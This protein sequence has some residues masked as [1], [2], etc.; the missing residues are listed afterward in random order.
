L[1]AKDVQIYLSKLA[2]P[3][4]VDQLQR[5]FK[6][7]PGEYAEKDILI[8]VYMPDLRKVASKNK[9]LPIAETK[10]LLKSKIHEERLL[11]LLIL[12]DQFKNGNLKDQETIYNLYLNNTQFINNWDLVDAS[13]HLIVGPFLEGK[14][15]KILEELA[16]SEN[17]WER[18]IAMMA[19]F[20]EIK[21]SKFK[22][23][24][25]IAKIL[26]NDSH[27]LIHKS[28]GWMLREVG[29][30]DLETEEQFLEK[31]ST[32]MPRTMLR[33]AIERF[34]KKKYRYFL[35]KKQSK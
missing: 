6:T 12:V 7:G 29:K 2:N 10:K 11:A 27:D 13:A 33:Y 31:H 19:T 17:L 14:S 4:R 25:K 32:K 22:T 23:A 34:P 15:K 26:L 20:N 16:K 8:G 9:T 35:E 30:R 28:V 21:K 5:F 24:L 3:G 18:R 1:K